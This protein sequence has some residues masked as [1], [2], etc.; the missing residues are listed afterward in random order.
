MTW[1]D[2][3]YASDEGPPEGCLALPRPTGAV[4]WL[5][6]AN[7][8]AFA[9]DM[10]S[11][12]VNQTFWCNTFGLSWNGIFSGHVWQPLTYMFTHADG[13]HL[14][15]NMLGLYIFGVEF[16][17]TFGRNRFLTF[18]AVCGLTGGIA[19]LAASAFGLTPRALPLLGASGAVYGLLIAAIIIFPHI[20][21]VVVVFPMPVRVFGLIVLGFLVLRLVGSGPAEERGA[22]I[23]H[24]AGAGAGIATLLRYKYA[25]RANG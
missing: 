17:R 19:Y 5:I 23:C 16:E 11:Q 18:Y 25:R 3:P 4:M 2:R 1:R 20:Q 14:L 6:V 13:W 15:F 22:E 7:V 12:H 10:I 24:A 21:I 8:V 9:A